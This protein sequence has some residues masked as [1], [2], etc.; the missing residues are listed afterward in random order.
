[1]VIWETTRACDLACQHCRAEAAPLPHRDQLTTVEARALIDQV[2][3]FGAPPPLFILTGGDPIKRPDL[4]SL[5]EYATA[6]RLPV[7]FSPS[8]TPLL[9]SQVIADVRAAGAVAMSLSLDGDTRAT[10]DAFRGVSGVFERTLD[11]GM[12]RFGT[13][14][15]CRSTRR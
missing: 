2:A 10:H 8:A 14:S 7:G 1:M 4:L 15:R 3:A 5:I 6:R 9:T 12:A 13:G 11:A